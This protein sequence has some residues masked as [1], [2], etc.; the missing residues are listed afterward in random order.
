MYYPQREVSK[1]ECERRSS[2]PKNRGFVKVGALT[3]SVKKS[4][5]NQFLGH[6]YKH[7]EFVPMDFNQ[8][9]PSPKGFE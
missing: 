7:L 4:Y 3:Q 2:S 9:T 1:Y 5:C 6:L 8:S